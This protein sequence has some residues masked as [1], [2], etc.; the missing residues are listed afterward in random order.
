MLGDAG[1]G[2]MKIYHGDILQF[3]MEDVFPA[4]IKNNWEDESP[5]IHLIGNLPFNVSTP[6][7]IRL[8]HAM[9]ERRGPWK[10]GRVKLTL[11]FQKE[12]ANRM[13]VGPGNKERCRLSLMCQYLCKVHPNF[14]IPGKFLLIYVSK[15]K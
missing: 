5:N 3:N 8:L 9:S 4:E 2:K 13:T 7:I 11:T 6:L 14:I 12:V 15:I 10:H 1:G